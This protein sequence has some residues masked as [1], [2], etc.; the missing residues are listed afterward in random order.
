M[1]AIT[2]DGEPSVYSASDIKMIL[3]FITDPVE[4]A[5][6]EAFLKGF[7]EV[8]AIMNDLNDSKQK[9]PENAVVMG[10]D[11]GID[12]IVKDVAELAEKITG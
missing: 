9:A 7:G 1:G 3:R 6:K 2:S 5:R 8:G 10:L 4:R 12:H 11:E